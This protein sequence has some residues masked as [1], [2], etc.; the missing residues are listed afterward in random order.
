MGVVQRAAGR[1]AAYFVFVVHIMAE[2]H[3]AMEVMVV[4]FLAI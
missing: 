2:L 3:L 1:P 4:A